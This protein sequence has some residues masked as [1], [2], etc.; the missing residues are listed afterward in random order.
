[1]T[2]HTYYFLII[3]MIQRYHAISWL[4]LVLRTEPESLGCT[5]P[6]GDKNQY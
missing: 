6:Y 1:M 4:S 2:L 5:C 3:F